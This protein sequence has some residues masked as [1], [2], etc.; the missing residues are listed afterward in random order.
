MGSLTGTS[1]DE[2][3]DAI[4]DQAREVLETISRLVV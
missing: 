3:R 2:F 4:G 1:D